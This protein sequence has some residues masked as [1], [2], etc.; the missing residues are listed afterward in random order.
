MTKNKTVGNFGEDLAV[1][2]IKK[3]KY[4]IL[5]RNVHEGKN[6]IDIIA[7]NKTTIVFVEVK[8]RC[9]ESADNIAFEVCA[10]S[11]V[12]F[13]KQKRTVSAA[14]AYLLENPTDKDI[15]FDVVEVY[16]DK[17]DQKKTFE[18]NHIENAF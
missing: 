1:K 17:K 6:E 11:A 4:K 8:T 3:K 18:I 16:L 7:A 15:R 2:Y 14:R 5:G 12:D 9:V 13:D 10:A